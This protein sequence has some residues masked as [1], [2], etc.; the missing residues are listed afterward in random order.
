MKHGQTSRDKESSFRSTRPLYNKSSF[1]KID[2]TPIYIDKKNNPYE[3]CSEPEQIYANASVIK[4]HSFA[5]SD[6]D[7]QHSSWKST[8]RTYRSGM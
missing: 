4:Q 1:G 7:H 3:P 6:V 2:S 5:K 8:E